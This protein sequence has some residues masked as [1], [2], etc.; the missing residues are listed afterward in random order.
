MQLTAL[1]GKRGS[2]AMAWR[3]PWQRKLGTGRP[4]SMRRIQE[5]NCCGPGRGGE[6]MVGNVPGRGRGMI[7]G[8]GDQ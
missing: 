4:P 6:G 8:D 5:R 7:L 2:P 1:A 3:T